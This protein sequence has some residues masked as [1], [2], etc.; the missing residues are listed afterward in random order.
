ME[1]RMKSYLNTKTDAFTLIELLVVIAII[2]I[3]AAILF[4]VFARVRE[5]ARRASCQNNLKQLS[6]T[7]IQY[8]QDYDGRLSGATGTG[9]STL[10]N[11]WHGAYMPYLKSNQTLFCPSVKSYTG[12][13]IMS[14]NAT[15]Y[16]FAAQW[17]PSTTNISVLSR[18]NSEMG[19]CANPPATPVTS[20]P[21]LLEAIPEPSRTC[22]IGETAERDA[23]GRFTGNGKPVFGSNREVGYRVSQSVHL[24]GSNYAYLD[25]HVKWLKNEAVDGVFAAQAASSPAGLTPTSAA[26]H[27]IVFLWKK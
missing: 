25:G 23:S 15:H 10:T 20:N 6:L 3:L 1:I 7:A 4:P 13:N 14:E 5:N 21:P 19:S 24:E 11:I 26:A 9:C 18:L 12:A 8:A 16:G 27:P 2:A 22:L 17:V